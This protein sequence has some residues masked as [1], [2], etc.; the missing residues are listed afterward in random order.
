MLGQ[1][2][3]ILKVIHGFPPDFMAGS[4]VYSFTL[5][6]ELAKM[7]HKVFVFTRVEN[8]F[9]EPYT[10]YDESYMNG[11]FLK[12]PRFED[13]NPNALSIRRINKPKDY[14]YRAKFYDDKLEAQFRAYL[15]QVQPD[16]VH[17]GHLAHLSI[18]LVKIA[19]AYNKP[20]VFTLHDFWL[21]CVRGQLIDSKLSL[22]NAPSTEKCLSCSPY[23]TLESEV[24]Q[25]LGHLQEVREDIDMF[26][27]PSHT[28]RDYFIKQG[29]PA[30]KILYQ[31][32]GFDKENITY[33]KRI[34][35]TQDSIRFGYM[36]RIIP[37]K[38][39]KVLLE[40]FCLLH[41]TYPKQKLRIYGDIGKSKRFLQEDFVE[42]M[43]GYDNGDIN[44]ILQDIDVLIVPSIWLENS[45][46]VIQEAFLAG[47]AVM[48]ADIGGMRELMA[49][50]RGL[51]FQAGNA[52]SLANALEQILQNP[53][54]LNALPDN[55][56]CVDSI[57]K[58]C[59]ATLSLYA[60]LLKEKQ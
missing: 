23:R 57:Q 12:A 4:E 60:R 31:K 19:K 49:N 51:C 29:I 10:I 28:L 11:E 56:E 38:G 39:I 53:S 3:K 15:E 41:A 18:N 52:S 42:F 45:P 48:S 37:T 43:G 32:Y 2:L 36:G 9:D 27:S 34:F 25:A 47:V 16:I 40:A 13:S 20:V 54:T 17:F 7:G 30:Q 55:R 6:K 58:D 1:T 14:T 44:A 26:I 46:L 50:G 33:K 5:C 35:K 21:Y 24:K 22:C 8:E 59:K